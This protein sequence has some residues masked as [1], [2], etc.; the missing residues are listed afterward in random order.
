M[1]GALSCCISKPRYLD[2]DNDY[3][4]DAAAAASR[5]V[6]PRDED[7]GRWGAGEPDVDSKA[8]SFIAKF[9]EARCMDAESYEARVVNREKQTPNPRSAN[10]QLFIA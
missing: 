1:G 6:S 4:C 7:W 2:D 9:H 5:R 8:S 3:S 10:H